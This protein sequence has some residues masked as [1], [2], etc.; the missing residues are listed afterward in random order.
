MSEQITP[1]ANFQSVRRVSVK[2]H[3]IGL[4]ARD[5]VVFNYQTIEHQNNSCQ[6]NSVRVEFFLS[7]KFTAWV[8]SSLI[9]IY[10][11]LVVIRIAFESEI[12]S[13][14][15]ELDILELVFLSIF[16]IEITLRIFAYKLVR[17][18]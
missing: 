5:G 7:H 4:G 8:L 11:I 13:V 18:N 9:I 6:S 1:V 16:V 12:I 3:S 15:T 14:N 2:R 17:L 10:S